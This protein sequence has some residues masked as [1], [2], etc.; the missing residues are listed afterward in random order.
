MAKLARAVIVRDPKRHRDLIFQAGDEPAL[1]HAVLIKN[2]ACWEGGKLPTA[3][4]RH[5][6]AKEEELAAGAAADTGGQETAATTV[7]PEP[8]KGD[9]VSGDASDSSDDQAAR[10]K[11]TAARKTAATKPARGRDAADQGDSGA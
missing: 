8:G 6:A 4:K 3:V 7:T 5:L 11:K 1:E 10:A 2:A 9:D